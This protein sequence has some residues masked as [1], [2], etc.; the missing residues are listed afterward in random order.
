MTE[1]IAIGE[2]QLAL[3]WDQ[4]EQCLAIIS[5]RFIQ[6]PDTTLF[7]PKGQRNLDSDASLYVKH[8]IS[9]YK[10]RKATAFTTIGQQAFEGRYWGKRLSEQPKMH[11]V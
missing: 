2:Q 9:A 3:R 8:F 4:H 6:E 5:P 1:Y 7:L 10:C 11:L